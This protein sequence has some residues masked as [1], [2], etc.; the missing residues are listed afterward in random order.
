ME[1]EEYRDSINLLTKALKS[2]LKNLP[3]EQ[4]SSLYFASTGAE[5]AVYIVECRMERD[6]DRT[7]IDELERAISKAERKTCRSRAA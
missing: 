3:N 4:D 1:K 2:V 5:L 6:N 7:D